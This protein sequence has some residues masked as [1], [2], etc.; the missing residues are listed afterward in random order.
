MHSEC[1]TAKSHLGICGVLGE[2]FVLWKWLDFSPKELHHHEKNTNF[3]KNIVRNLLESIFRGEN[4]PGEFAFLAANWWK[5]EG[6]HN[7]PMPPKTPRNY[8]LENLTCPLKRDCFNRKYIFQPLILRGHVSFRGSRP[9]MKGIV[10]RDY[11]AHHVPFIFGLF[12]R[13]Y[14]SE[15]VTLLGGSSHLV[16]G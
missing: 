10:I 9:D 4:S 3:W 14:S 11:E 16:S 13:H 5:I 1:H 2:C 15:R 12:E 7:C 6:A 8:T